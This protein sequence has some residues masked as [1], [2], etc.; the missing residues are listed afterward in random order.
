[1]ITEIR[2]PTAFRRCIMKFRPTLTIIAVAV[3][4]AFLVLAAVACG[5][6]EEKQTPAATATP[7]AEETPAPA[8]T[9]TPEK[10]KTPSGR[11][12]ELPDIAAYPGAKETF[13]GT[14]TGEGLPLPVPGESP[15]EPQE[16]G[17]TAY[18]V[19]Q[20]DDSVDDVYDF[21]KKEFKGWKEEWTWSTEAAG[22]KVRWGVWSKDDRSVAAWVLAGEEDGKTSV[23]VVRAAQD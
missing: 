8:E 20:T 13:S 17:K 23:T 21:Y 22:G 11:A 3:A 18:T 9:A 2:K 16:Y 5:G 15:L 19:F 1:M 14:F 12:G 4:A 10:E 6:A 7:K